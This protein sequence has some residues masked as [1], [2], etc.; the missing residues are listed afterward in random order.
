MKVSIIIPYRKDRGYLKEAVDSA[1][2]QDGFTIGVDYEVI[3]QKGEY[4]LGKNI[5]DAVKKAKGRYIKILADDDLLTPNCLLDLYS[6]A[7]QGFDFVCADAIDFGLPE[8]DIYH[9]SLLPRTVNELARENTIHGG[10]ILYRKETMPLWDEDLWSAEEY[11]M[12][13]RMAAMGLRFGYVDKVVYKYRIHSQRKTDEWVDVY[14]TGEKEYRKDY[15]DRVI[16]SKYLGKLIVI[17]R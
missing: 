10:S 13:L 12:S 5:N 7:E 4:R 11:E 15:R 16:V 3:L 8:G 9:P 6:K 1:S 2:N 14:R 17:N